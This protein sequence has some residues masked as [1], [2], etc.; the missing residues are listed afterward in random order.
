[1]SEASGER[2]EKVI[3]TLER[4]DRQVQDLA[5]RNNAAIDDDVPEP[6]SRRS[7]AR[8]RRSEQGSTAE[9]THLDA[10]RDDGPHPDFDAGF[11]DRSEYD[12]DRTSEPWSGQRFGDDHSERDSLSY[13]EFDDRP[14]KRRARRTHEDPQA[15]IY[16]DLSRRIDALRRPQERAFEQVREEL[17]SLRNALGGLSKGT[18]E[19][20]NRQNAELRR[21]SDMVERLRGDRRDEQ[22]A[23]DIRREVAELKAMV[24][25][26]NVEGSLETL[27]HGYA[28]ILQR[29]DELSRAAIDPR[30]L[31]GV[32]ARLNEIEDA[33]AVLPRS[34]HFAALEDRIAV[35][36]ERMEDLLQRKGHSE[37]EPL[38]AELRE[39]RQFVEHM[40]I[41]GLVDGIDDRLKFVSGRLDDLEALAREHRVLDTRL[42]AMEQRMPE[43]DTIARLQGRLEDIVGMMSDDR[44]GAVGQDQ[45][46]SVDTRLNEIVGRLERMEQAAPAGIDDKAFDAL[47]KRLVAISAKID[48]I[49][50]KTNRPVPVPELSAL[51]EGASADTALFAQLQ[52]RLNDLSE[53]LETPQDTVTTGDL[54]KLRAEIGAM[55]SAVS[56][57]PATDALEKRISDLAAAVSNGGAGGDRIDQLAVKVSAL[58]EQLETR[59]GTEANTGGVTAVLERIEQGLADTRRDVVDIARKTAQEAIS[60][61]P[62]ARAAEYD[63]AI[64][65][66]QG[67]LKRLL[68]A[69]DGSEERTRNTFD[70]VQSVLASLTE[71]LEH[72]ERS[73]VTRPASPSTYIAELEQDRLYESAASDREATAATAIPD[74]DRPAE[75]VRDRKADFIAAA[76]RAAQAASAEAAKMDSGTPVMVTDEDLADGGSGAKRAGWFRK[77]LGRRNPKASQEDTDRPVEPNVSGGETSSGGEQI[78]QSGPV[79]AGDRPAPSD[80]VE[81]GG[82]RRKALLF[83]AAAVVLALGTLQVF[84]LATAPS[85]DEEQL[86]VSEGALIAP[87]PSAGSSPQA[88]AEEAGRD[89]GAPP[90]GMAPPAVQGRSE[91][92][93]AGNPNAVSLPAG[94][95]PA[96]T[97]ADPARPGDRSAGA[98]NGVV[99]GGANL[100]SPAE[101]R[102]E[103]AFAPPS[104][105]SNGFGESGPDVDGFSPPAVSADPAT[106]AQPA[107]LIANLPPEEVGPIA[108]R[109]A[110]AAGNPQA[111]FLVGVKYTEGEGIAADLVEA[112]KWYQIAADKGLPPAQYRLASLYEKGR[113]VAKDLPKARDW[114][115]KAAEAGNAKAMHNLAVMYAE[116][117]NGTPS[118]ADAAKWFEEAAN[119]GVQD[120]LFNLGILYAR[121]LGVE[122]DLGESYKWFAI[123]ADQGDQDAAKKRDDV[124]NAMD[125]AQLAAARLAVESFE[126]KTP[127]AAANKVVTDPEWIETSAQPTNAAVNLG[128]VVNYTA[129]VEQAQTKLNA[130]GF[131]TGI[132]DGQVGPRTRSAVR[133]F[134]RSLGLPETGEIDAG[135][136]QELERK[137]I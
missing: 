83:A 21:L 11:P 3:S 62:A 61:Q 1:M 39:V 20:V 118:F 105:V 30:I 52:T 103:V 41:A 84:K 26:T 23:K 57:A 110:A 121:G 13:D 25:R 85:V 29:L 55:R 114:Y 78:N 95:L 120:S 60:A 125:Q 34:E 47:E 37:I 117:A 6:E 56:A 71:R 54:D 91:A 50:E 119:F 98:G 87:S 73:G 65:G 36:S 127:D 68:D 45:L 69:A 66:L 33:F 137:S 32:T 108:L 92:A 53:R 38:R 111:A 19:K 102:P 113:G 135:L 130:L 64:A 40:D 43:P 48:Q 76:R 59:A 75:R 58:A 96:S 77:V 106:A 28:H 132:P 128:G 90:A 46:G 9:N 31:K 88:I 17:G 22:F 126:V 67:D 124:A 122:K 7:A 86:A 109:S 2:L 133:A 107:S 51:P 12:R 63:E 16:R 5:T 72:I 70:G 94:T 100:V 79:L 82:G 89:A 112:A 4:L 49:E 93:D 115:L 27:E 81:S 80:G 101:P 14:L 10:P 104:G 99:D 35:I 116:G 18:H 131:D 97:D 8:R 42:S 24:G 15:P 129:M 44:A 136:M 74:P 123:A 134:Q